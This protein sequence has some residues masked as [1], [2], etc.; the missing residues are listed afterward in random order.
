MADEVRIRYQDYS[1]PEISILEY[2]FYDLQVGEEIDMKEEM[3]SNKKTA[4]V[5]IFA[6]FFSF[7]LGSSPKHAFRYKAKRT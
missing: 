2:V 5:F 3:K 4:K 7:A 6:V 1:K